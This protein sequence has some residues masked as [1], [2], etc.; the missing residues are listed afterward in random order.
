MVGKKTI[1]MDLEMETAF[2]WIKSVQ[3]RHEVGT[4]IKRIQKF[5]FPKNRKFL[6]RLNNYQISS[7]KFDRRSSWL[8]N[9]LESGWTMK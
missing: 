6:A 8:S 1:I 9:V 2:N 5:R 7:K 3:C 4:F